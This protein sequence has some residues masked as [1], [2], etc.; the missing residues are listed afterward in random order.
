MYATLKPF[1]NKDR[2]PSKC[3]VAPQLEAIVLGAKAFRAFALA[4]GF[5]LRGGPVYATPNLSFMSS[6]LE[7]P[8]MFL[9][10]SLRALLTSIGKLIRLIA[11]LNGN[12]QG[13]LGCR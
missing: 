5:V 8:F 1:D 6:V 11:L 10:F 7:S 4:A 2:D 9:C 3:W 12:R 13:L